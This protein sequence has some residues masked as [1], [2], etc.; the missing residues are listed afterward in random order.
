MNVTIDQ[1]RVCVPTNSYDWVC[2]DVLEKID[3]RVMELSDYQSQK[4]DLHEAI[5]LIF[6]DAALHDQTYSTVRL[7]I[8]QAI[9]TFEVVKDLNKINLGDSE[10]EKRLSRIRKSIT[11][12]INEAQSLLN[13]RPKY[14]L[15][16]G[17]INCALPLD[18]SWLRPHLNGQLIMVVLALLKG[19]LQI[20]GRCHER[21]SDMRPHS[22]RGR[23]KNEAFDHFI[24]SLIDIYSLHSGR[25]PGTS[26]DHYE[27]KRTGPMVRFIEAVLKSIDPTEDR[28]TLGQTVQ[29]L[30]QENRKKYGMQKLFE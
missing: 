6:G 10:I 2:S 27:E 18:E 9:A 3:R 4:A 21:F 17:G 11:D 29:R 23:P 5:L 16:G 26:Y 7:D 28:R 13:G 19:T 1:D 25:E 15:F 24:C 8:I 30:L 12:A 14:R 20:L 22:R